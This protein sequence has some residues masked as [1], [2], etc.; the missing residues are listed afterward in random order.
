MSRLAVLLLRAYQRLLS[1]LLGPRCKYSPTCSEYA[2][3]AISTCGILRGAVLAGWRVV[4]CN[5]WS[6]GGHDPVSARRL[7]RAPAAGPGAPSPVN[8]QAF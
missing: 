4:R 6:H 3:Q 2:V 1:P 8:H 7:F 5:P